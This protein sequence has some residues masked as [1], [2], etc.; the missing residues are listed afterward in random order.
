MFVVEVMGKFSKKNEEFY[1][2]NQGKKNRYFSKAASFPT[3]ESAEVAGRL[4]VE[5]GKG[6]GFQVNA[7]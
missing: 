3:A 4:F 7:A 5:S 6:Y 2:D 1:L